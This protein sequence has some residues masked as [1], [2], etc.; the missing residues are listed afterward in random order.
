M[1]VK[2]MR[3]GR[4]IKLTKHCPSCNFSR[5]KPLE[6]PRR[7]I[8]GFSMIIIAQ[9]PVCGYAYGVPEEEVKQ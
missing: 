1:Q 7:V 8:Y 4:E 3:N 5:F 6:A 2:L 9:C